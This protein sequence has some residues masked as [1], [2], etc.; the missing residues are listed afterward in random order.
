M[1][2]SA[3][4]KRKIAR[5]VKKY[6]ACARKGG[7]GKKKAPPPRRSKRLQKRK[8]TKGSPSKTRPGDKD[9]TT[10]KGDKDFHRRGHDVKGSRKP[11]TI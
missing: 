3:E 2:M 4:H 10:K 9:F 1:V 11:Y 6:H 7:C 5:G 8:M